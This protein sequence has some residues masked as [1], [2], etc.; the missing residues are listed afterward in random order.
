MRF[1]I[2]YD[3]FQSLQ[4]L[5]IPMSLS[6]FLLSNVGIVP[7]YSTLLLIIT[8]FLFSVKKLKSI[9]L[10]QLS[11][12][13]IIIICL[14]I[15]WSVLESLFYLDFGHIAD[16]FNYVTILFIYVIILTIKDLSIISNLYLK[17]ILLVSSFAGI[18]F[19]LALF[20]LV[21]PQVLDVGG[22]NV[23]YR[24]FLTYTGTVDKFHNLTLIRPA[25]VFYEAGALGIYIMLAIYINRINAFSLKNEYL[26]LFLGLC[27][28]SFGF[29]ISAFIYIVSF[30][31]TR[32]V[33]FI[34]G[35][36]ALLFFLSNTL[37]FDHPIFVRI[38]DVFFRRF[39]L[40]DEFVGF[41]GFGNRISQNERSFD[42]IAENPLFG[43]TYGDIHISSS[44]GG[45][46]AKHGLIGSTILLSSLFYLFMLTVTYALKIRYIALSVIPF[47]L[48]INIFH[49]PYSNRIIYALI[50]LVIFEIVRRNYILLGRKRFL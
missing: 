13:M 41:K 26:L 1:S 27:T 14:Q 15:C 37:F 31:K 50:V 44:I 38:N 25:G 21:E 5:I 28:L 45:F 42:L 43:T 2:R 23:L 10:D 34:L 36:I 47:L 8:V 35:G 39:E 6:P 46:I 18:S 4:L 7:K 3:W 17:F 49:R 40:S 30:Y 12:V 11:S 33:L 29:A 22:E 20:E 9:Q 32:I 48:I 16:I 19:L 24:V